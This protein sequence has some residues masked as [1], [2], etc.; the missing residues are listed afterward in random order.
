MKKARKQLVMSLLSCSLVAMNFMGTS[1]TFAADTVQPISLS[2]KDQEIL[3]GTRVIK[4]VT[5]NK[6]D[7]LTLSID[8]NPVAAEQFQNVQPELLV[9]VNGF[10]SG[11]KNGIMIGDQVVKVI[12]GKVTN[13]ETV[14]VPI[15]ESLLHTGANTISLHSGNSTAPNSTTGNN[16]DFSVE[17]VRLVL[18]DGTVL[19]VEDVKVKMGD[20]SQVTLSPT[21]RVSLGDGLPAND[22]MAKEM[23]DFLFTLPEINFA[24]KQYTWDTTKTADGKHTVTLSAKGPDGEKQ[25]ISNVVV[26]NTAPV[27]ESISPID[28]KE[29]K[30]NIDFHA[31]A[32][33]AT[34]GIDKLEAKLDGEAI[35]LPAS[36]AGLDMKPGTHQFSVNATDKAG[37]KQTAEAAFVVLEEHPYKPT[38]P[39]PVD[40]EERASQ[41]PKLSVLV[42]DPTKDPLDVTFLQGY[43]TDLKER[44]S[45]KAFV[46]TTDREPPLEMEAAGEKEFADDQYASVEAKDGKYLTTNSKDKFPYHRFDLK[47]EQDLSDIEDVEVMWEG[48]SLPHRQVTLYTWNFNTKQW[49]AGARGM[50]DKDFTLKAKVN[51]ED[52]VRDNVVHVLVQDLI[53]SP[54]AYDFTFAWITDTQYYSEKYPHIYDSMNQYIVD[55]RD[56]LKIDYTIHTGDIVD[57]WDSPQ[58]WAN[59]D[60]SMKI[61]DDAKMPYGVVSGNHDVNFEKADYAEYYKYFGRDRFVNQPTYGG[62]LENNRDHY[63]LVSSNGNDFIFLY[64]GW[65]IDQQTIDWANDVLKKYPNRNAIVATHMYISPNGKYSGQGQEMWDKVVAN[66][67]NVF[68]VVCGHHH[69]VAY[70]VKHAPDG[71]TVIEMLYDYQSG[72][73]GGSGYLRLLHFDTEHQQLIVNTYSPYKNDYNFYEDSSKDEFTLP[74]KLKPVEKQVATDYI[75][76]NLYGKKVID[77]QS[78]VK[79]DTL[80]KAHWKGLGKDGTFFWYVRLADQ[81][82][83]RQVSDIWGFTTKAEAE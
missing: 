72:P 47:L 49:V 31:N 10:D 18:G 55:N 46:N 76:V 4:G 66:N 50:G 44:A 1:Q 41:N 13:F 59:A 65:S 39:T 35:K 57:S 37:N 80:A 54:D 27:F 69:G 26:D 40:G 2:V 16:D 82:G 23:A 56:K 52:M 75:A 62:D 17:N 63:D 58:Q 77:K 8:G 24:A 60:K 12:D 22:L 43:R 51:V 30:G 14:R 15:P 38:Q 83:G 64:L 74:L 19:P 11:Y 21:G 7:Q 73:E 81:Y 9:D 70:N 34:T 20:G 78:A 36:I 29:Y 48:H 28:G 5:N 79:S 33:D 68:M 32:S 42:S 53:P 25:A 61:L 71:R 45:N 6:A 67:Q 3:K